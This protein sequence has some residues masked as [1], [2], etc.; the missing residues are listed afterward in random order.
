MEEKTEHVTADEAEIVSSESNDKDAEGEFIEQPAKVMR[1]GSML[2]QL[3]DELREVQLDEGSRDR[4]RDIYETSVK[5]LGSALSQ[6]LRDELDRITLPFGTD[7]IPSEAELR[8][9][10]AQLVGWLEGLIQGIQA[11]LFAQQMATQQQL[12]SMRSG[13]ELLPGSKQVA[14]GDE[15][16]GNEQNRPGTYL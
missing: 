9:A 13:G 15:S 14:S 2:R 3:L 16:D 1:V 8:V 6:E 11:T 5:E 12:A 10:Q 4:M 7:E